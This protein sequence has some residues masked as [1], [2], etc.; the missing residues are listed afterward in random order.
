MRPSAAV[1]RRRGL[2]DPDD[3]AALPARVPGHRLSNTLLVTLV[4]V[5]ENNSAR[6]ETA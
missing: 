2:F 1:G 5:C 3:I 6:G 4:T